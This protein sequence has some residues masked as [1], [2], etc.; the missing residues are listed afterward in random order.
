LTGGV[1]GVAG[2]NNNREK[3]SALIDANS[4]DMKF[5][6]VRNIRELEDLDYSAS[7]RIVDSNARV[8]KASIKNETPRKLMG[9]SGQTSPR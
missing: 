5:G 7:I 3:P 6:I 2:V 1:E 9:S 4:A 8:P